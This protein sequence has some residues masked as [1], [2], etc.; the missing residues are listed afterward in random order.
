MP[1]Y[2]RPV[3]ANDEQ[4]IYRL[5]YQQ[6]FQQLCAWLWDPSVRDHLL[7]IQI[8]G[9]EATYASVWPHADYAIIM[10]DDHPVGRLIV[11]RVG[12]HFRLVDIT[13]DEKHRGAGIGTR[14]VLALCME[15]EMQ[16][17]S[18]RLYVSVTN[19]R[20]TALYNRL[21][22]REIE[23]DEAGCVM[24]RSPGAISQVI[25]AP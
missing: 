19:P 12:A 17:K 5:V 10:L 8:R 14:I 15:A 3:Q 22:F 21:G 9:Q 23:K 6:F 1:L 11:N 24:E 25:A 20:A 13:L 16:Q 7:N 18:V 4:F 2:V